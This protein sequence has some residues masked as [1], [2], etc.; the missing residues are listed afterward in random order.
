M[1]HIFK[2]FRHFLGHF[3]AIFLVAGKHIRWNTLAR[4]SLSRETRSSILEHARTFTHVLSFQIISVQ[5][6]WFNNELCTNPKV[7]VKKI[8]KKYVYKVFHEIKRERCS[9]VFG[10]S[11]SLAAAQPGDGER[12]TPAGQSH[13]LQ[14]HAWWGA[15]LC[16]G[17][18]RHRSRQAR[19]LKSTIQQ[20]WGP[21]FFNAFLSFLMNF[22]SFKTY[23]I[24]IL[25]CLFVM[26]LTQQQIQTTRR[27]LSRKIKMLLF[28]FLYP[29]RHGNPWPRVFWV[30]R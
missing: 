26:S 21:F 6:F 23:K 28:L 7:I 3:L 27:L 30:A 12:E 15:S 29:H 16:D 10:S 22:I 18:R 17:F 20:S 1:S 25:V 11:D 13:Q 24:C 5:A 9:H 2:F 8:I 4:P 14:L 19:P